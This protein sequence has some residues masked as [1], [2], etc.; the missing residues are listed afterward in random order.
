[1]IIEISC[2]A[3][4]SRAM[5]HCSQEASLN[6]RPPVLCAHTIVEHDPPNWR[7]GRT[8][9]FGPVGPR[10]GK[11]TPREQLDDQMSWVG[12]A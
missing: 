10:V 2:S 3:D 9:P 8:Q 1:M 6:V 11:G 12:E 7:P 4:E 5:L